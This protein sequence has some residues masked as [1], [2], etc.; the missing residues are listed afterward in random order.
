[1]VE[2]PALLLMFCYRVRHLRWRGDDAC[3]LIENPC[4]AL[5]PLCFVQPLPAGHSAADGL[6]GNGIGNK[7]QF[8]RKGGQE[9]EK[10]MPQFLFSLLRG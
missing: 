5:V 9:G 1:M 3:T 6:C 10:Y 8:I 4:S 7:Y 2:F